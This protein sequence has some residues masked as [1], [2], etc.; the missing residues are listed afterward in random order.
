MK[1]TVGR[2]LHFYMWT[3]SKHQGPHAATVASVHD[4]GSVTI[5]FLNTNGAPSS[6]RHVILLAEGQEAPQHDYCVWPPRA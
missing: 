1:P 3:G 4:D 6:K 2:C 5:G